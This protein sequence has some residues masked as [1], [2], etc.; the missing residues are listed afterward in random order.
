M[1][2]AVVLMAVRSCRFWRARSGDDKIRI[3]D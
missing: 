1:V 2:G 3:A